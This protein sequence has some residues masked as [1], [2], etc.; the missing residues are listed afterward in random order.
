VKSGAQDEIIGRLNAAVNT[1]LAK[2]KVR[3]SFASLGYEPA[4]GTPAE[5]GALI[6]SQVAY[7]AKIVKDSG[8]KMPQ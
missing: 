8:I 4:G 1:A 5:F 2:Q 3:R 7:W 6:A